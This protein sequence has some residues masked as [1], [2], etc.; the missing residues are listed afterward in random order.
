M[1]EVAPRARI[2]NYTNPVNIVAQ[3]ATMHSGRALHLVLRGD[4]RLPQ[5]I[6][7]AAGLDPARISAR[8]IGLNHTT[9]SVSSEYDGQDAM[10]AIER[11]WEGMRDEAGVDPMT[12][13]SWSWP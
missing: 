13:A 5:E 2:F 8:T 6:A 1:D 12:D 10:L 4:L 9:W 11:A 7:Q 3:A